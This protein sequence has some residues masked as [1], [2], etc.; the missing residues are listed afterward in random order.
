[1]EL[2]GQS[3]CLDTQEQRNALNV[4]LQQAV[5]PIPAGREAAGLCFSSRLKPVNRLMGVLTPPLCAGIGLTALFSSFCGDLN[6][7]SPEP[8]SRASAD[9]HPDA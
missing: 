1:M 5:G 3:R 4:L 2:Q 6:S 7:I 9:S 8:Q